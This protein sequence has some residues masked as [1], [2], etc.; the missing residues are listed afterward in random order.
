MRAMQLERVHKYDAA[1]D[2]YAQIL[3]KNHNNQFAKERLTALQR[4]KHGLPVQRPYASPVRESLP[5]SEKYETAQPHRQNL[6]AINPGPPGTARSIAA[7]GPAATRSVPTTQ[8]PRNVP[9]QASTNVPP[10]ARAPEARPQTETK[11]D[12]NTRK[13]IPLDQVMAR[14]VQPEPAQPAPRKDVRASRAVS[15]PA[16]YDAQ[17][18]REARN[19]GSP[20]GVSQVSMTT[21]LPAIAQPERPG[22]APEELTLVE[23]QKRLSARPADPSTIEMLVQGIRTEDRTGRWEISTTLGVLIQNPDAKPLIVDSLTRALTDRE[24]EMRRDTALVIASLG[25]QAKELLPALKTRHTDPEETV[26]AAAAYAI[27]EIR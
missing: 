20:S 11:A 3:N 25:G 18:I 26:R 23:I 21:T 10:W 27:R 4:L 19:S 2:V 7:V 17:M 9:G 16:I 15:L 14:T 6:P 1:A 22:T 13:R 8:P 24:P 12:Q 5:A